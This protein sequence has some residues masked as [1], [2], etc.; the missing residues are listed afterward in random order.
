MVILLV[1]LYYYVI[2][3]ELAG[4]FYG[5]ATR[6]IMWV[7]IITLP[8][9]A[10]WNNM[11]QMWPDIVPVPCA[12]KTAAM[13]EDYAGKLKEIFQVKNLTPHERLT[14]ITKEQARVEARTNFC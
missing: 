6:P 1:L 13:I 7:C 12:K 10:M 9:V 11:V 4:D 2:I 5:N 14:R 3:P 8:P